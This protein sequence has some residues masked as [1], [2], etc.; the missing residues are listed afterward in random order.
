[1]TDVVNPSD[2]ELVFSQTL[3]DVCE[4][5]ADDCEATLRSLLKVAPSEEPFLRESL[6]LLSRS[7]TSRVEE[8]LEHHRSALRNGR[9]WSEA[10]L[11]TAR[12]ASEVKKHD[13]R[14]ELEA[15]ALRKVEEASTRLSK[16]HAAVIEAE[17]EAAKLER[18]QLD[19]NLQL[20]ITT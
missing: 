18:D 17:R 8:L 1:M 2:A 6:E 20:T 5:I 13:L 11:S 15:E 10:R 14:S 16:E 4:L 19:R 9:R 12:R 3:S 7:S